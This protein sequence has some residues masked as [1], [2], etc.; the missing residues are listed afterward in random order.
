LRR[1]GMERRKAGVWMLLFLMTMTISAMTLLAGCK[2]EPT[3][4]S[5]WRDREIRV[6]GDDLEWQGCPQYYDEA[7]RIAIRL[8]NDESHLFVCLF[9]HDRDVGRQI[10]VQG[11]TLWLEQ[12]DEGPRKIGVHFPVGLPRGERRPMLQ[13]PS[14]GRPGA[15]D[16]PPEEKAGSDRK[17]PKEPPIPMRESPKIELTEIQMLGPGE[18]EQK[19]MAIAEIA[20]Y[21]V[22]VT[23]NE[24]ERGLVYELSIPVTK[25]KGPQ[26][27]LVHPRKEGFR[28][29]LQVGEMG[30]REKVAKPGNIGRSTPDGRGGDKGGTGPP[31]KGGGGGQPGG[32]DGP[33]QAPRG[34]KGERASLN[35]WLK[36]TGL[37]EKASDH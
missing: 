26:Y 4:N 9:S 3:I 2:D 10:I 29:G 37:A 23:V 8:L 15:L 6:D 7:T 22:A 12:Q 25:E 28:L 13:G 32:R 16:H 27:G 34:E 30:T 20:K 17:P 31:R 21:D 33:S 1:I 18:F 19:T 11:F 36:V 5:S 14:A 35:L 24:T